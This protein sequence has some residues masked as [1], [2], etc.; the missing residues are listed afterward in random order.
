MLFFSIFCLAAC[1]LIGGI[2]FI[3]CEVVDKLPETNKF[4]Q[5][6]KKHLMDIDF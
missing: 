6:W 1:F 4:K 3:D 5:W 2:L